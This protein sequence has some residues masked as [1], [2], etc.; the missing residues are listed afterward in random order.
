MGFTSSSRKLLAEYA[1][2]HG[3]ASNTNSST[4]ISQKTGAKTV[5]K[6]AGAA[7]I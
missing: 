4:L 2:I 5:Y 7:R 3:F 6:D 1:E